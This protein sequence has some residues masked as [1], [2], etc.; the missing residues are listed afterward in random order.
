MLRKRQELAEQVAPLESR[1][2]ELSSDLV[3]VDEAEKK[4]ETQLLSLKAMNQREKL[5]RMVNG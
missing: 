1:L 3:Q 5:S 2:N 4:L